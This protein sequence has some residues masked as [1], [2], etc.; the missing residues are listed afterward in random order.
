MWRAVTQPK[1]TLDMSEGHV[2]PQ[3]RSG[4]EAGARVER[5]GGTVREAVIFVCCGCWV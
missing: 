3:L 1:H 2:F 4:M 5:E